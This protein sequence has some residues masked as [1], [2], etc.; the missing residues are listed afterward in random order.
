MFAVL[1]FTKGWIKNTHLLSFLKVPFK[2]NDYYRIQ[3]IIEGHKEKRANQKKNA[4][5]SSQL[6]PIKEV[7]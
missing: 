4:N 5:R 6:P 2:R 3:L 7:A 1:E